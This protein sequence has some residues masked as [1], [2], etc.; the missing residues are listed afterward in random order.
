MGEDIAAGRPTELSARTSFVGACRR[1]LLG[2]FCGGADRLV[3][4][5]PV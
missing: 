4:Q 2:F 5:S 3:T 1:R